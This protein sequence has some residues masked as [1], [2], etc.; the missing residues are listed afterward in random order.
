MHTH[1]QTCK[2]LLPTELCMEQLLVKLSFLLSGT[3][4][5][6]PCLTVVFLEMVHLEDGHQV[7]WGL[8]LNMN[9]VE[10]QPLPS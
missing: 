6:F 4:K 9:H 7:W 1:T 10:W 5:E 8:V 2:A 3:L